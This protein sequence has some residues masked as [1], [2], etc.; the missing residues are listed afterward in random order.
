MGCVTVDT[1]EWSQAIFTVGLQ[2]PLI[3]I[4]E[5]YKSYKKSYHRASYL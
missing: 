1:I 2:V 4:L 3:A 5:L